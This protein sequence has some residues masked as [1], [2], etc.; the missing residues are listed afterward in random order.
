MMHQSNM[1]VLPKG[2]V[3][4]KKTLKA[5][6]RIIIN[7]ERPLSLYFQLDIDINQTPHPE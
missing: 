4:L 6:W 7:L 5:F 1:V 2:W 3:I